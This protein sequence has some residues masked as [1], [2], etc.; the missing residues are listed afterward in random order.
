MESVVMLIGS[1]LANTLAFTGGSYLFSRLSKDNIDAK[2]ERHDLVT[3][4][5]QKAQMEW[6]QKRQ[7]QINFMN[8]QLRLE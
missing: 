1:A 4:Q 3:E 8:E 7:Q 6:A 2:T 5:L